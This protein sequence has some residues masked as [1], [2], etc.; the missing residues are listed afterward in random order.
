MNKQQGFTLI[1]LMIVVAIIGVLSAV[2]IPAYKNYVTKSEVASAMATMKA[3]ITPLEARIQEKGFE[4]T[5]S[6]SLADIGTN[7]NANPLGAIT[8]PASVTSAA[9]SLIF[10]FDADSSVNG[11]K[12]TFQKN[13][14]SNGVWTCIQDTGVEIKGCP[15]S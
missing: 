9:S 3:L 4:G 5:P 10:T 6:Y 2:A 14:A 8:D 15:A 7:A 12:V 11:K 13:A 1:E